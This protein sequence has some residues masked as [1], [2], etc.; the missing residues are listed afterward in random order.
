MV[1]LVNICNFR[2]CGDASATKKQNFLI[3]NDES[4][5]SDSENENI[6]S[7][8]ESKAEI[9][10]L[11]NPLLE[12]K[13]PKPDLGKLSC[14]PESSKGSVFTNHYETAEI[15]KKS[16]L[17]KHVKMTEGQFQTGKKAK[18]C[19]K[20]KQGRCFYGNNCQYS[21]DI[22]S[23]LSLRYKKDEPVLPDDSAGSSAPHL[24]RH[25]NPNAPQLPPPPVAKGFMGTMS[26]LNSTPTPRYTE[27]QRRQFKQQ[28]TYMKKLNEGDD[29]DDDKF[30]IGDKRKK[31]VGVSQTLVP[32]KK[33]MTAL[34][35]QR[36]Q[37]R[38]WTLKN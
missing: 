1:K 18:T 10:K 14:I 13:L 21:H 20:F 6:L 9:E 35:K 31:R 28:E 2:Q 30:N 24:K 15:A 5:S 11:P 38:P 26:T 8:T 22:D 33:A 17:E 19:R 32:P 37:E 34:T 16:I 23:N 4:E 27:K 3:A 25:N 29:G 7:G 12:N 36:E